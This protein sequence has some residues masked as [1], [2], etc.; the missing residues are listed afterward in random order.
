MPRS[1]QEN[2][3]QAPNE[4]SGDMIMNSTHHDYLSPN[5]PRSGRGAIVAACASALL[6]AMLLGGCA[7]F[8]GIGSAAKLESPDQLASGATLPG[9]GGRWPAQDWATTIGGK[10][11][12]DLIDEALAGNPGLQVAAARV[13]GARAMAEGAKAASSPTVGAGFNDTYQRFTEHGLIPPPYAGGYYSDGELALNFAYDFDF[14][15]KHSAEL[16]AAVSDEKAAQ[17]EQYSARLV[18]STAI[19]RSWIQLGRQYQQLDLVERQQ[20]IRTQFDKLT[21]LRVAG[22]L[23]TQTD[24]QQTILQTAALRNEQAQWQEAI[25][26]TRNQLAALLGQGPDRGG[27]IARP[28]LPAEEL[29]NL[30]DN[31]PLDLLGRRPDIVAARWRVE[32]AQGDIDNAKAQFYPNV[33]LSAFLGASSLGAG[34]SLDQL[35]KSGSRVVGVGP[36]I[37][38]PIFEGGRLRAQLKGRV[39]SYDGAIAGYNQTLTDALHDVADQVQSMRYAT[40]QAD[41]QRVATQAAAANFKLAQQRE[42]VGTVNMLAVL[43][44]E[45]ALLAQRKL[46]FDIQARRADLRVSLIKA[47]GGGFDA[48]AQ[49]LALPSQATPASKAAQPVTSSNQKNENSAS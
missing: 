30:P 24:K 7:N 34:L 5:F 28:A 38:M 46:D 31:L 6:A 18:L 21:Q 20:A 48:N 27:N 32:A 35:F 39:A 40:I 19:A 42:Q 41:N 3:I 33:N 14:W 26:L 11:L 9:Q 16:R 4:H 44:S 47:M 25:A 45:S 37:S 8:K 1:L 36:A 15:G 49:G 23:D 10:P 12:Q 2:R 43:S 29:A 17:A 22:G 13:N